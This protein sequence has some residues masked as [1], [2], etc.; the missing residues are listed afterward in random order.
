MPPRNHS[1]T[2]QPFCRME[3]VMVASALLWVLGPALCAVDPPVL[4]ALRDLY[5]SANGPRYWSN[6]NGWSSLESGNVTDPCD[7]TWHGVLCTDSNTSITYVPGT[8]LIIAH[9]A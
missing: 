7:N 3:P 6:L 4:A 5:E 8:S 9:E 2:C 1:S